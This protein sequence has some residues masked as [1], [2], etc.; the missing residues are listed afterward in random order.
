MSV[1]GN[2]E[3]AKAE[4]ILDGHLGLGKQLSKAVKHGLR[5]SSSHVEQ[6]EYTRWNIFLSKCHIR[7]WHHLA[8]IQND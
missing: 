4:K 2:K 5:S 6:L 7:F 8:S 1:A 3:K